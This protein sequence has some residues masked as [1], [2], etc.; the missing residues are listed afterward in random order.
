MHRELDINRLTP[1][2]GDY[3]IDLQEGKRF[4]DTRDVAEG[5]FFVQVK[6]EVMRRPTFSSFLALLVRTLFVNRPIVD[7]SLSIMKSLIV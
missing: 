1:E 5:R 4:G 3:E 7:S 2:N 6:R